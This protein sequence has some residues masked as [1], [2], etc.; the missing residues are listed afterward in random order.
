MFIPIIG[1]TDHFYIGIAN[2]EACLHVKKR[3][4]FERKINIIF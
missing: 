2:N 3:I 1:Q 4:N